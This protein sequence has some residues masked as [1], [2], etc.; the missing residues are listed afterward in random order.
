MPTPSS[1]SLKKNEELDNTKVNH[2][3]TINEFNDGKHP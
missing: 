2:Q 1:R 3:T